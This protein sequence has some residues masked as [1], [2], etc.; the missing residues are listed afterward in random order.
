MTVLL[1]AIVTGVLIIFIARLL[2][3]YFTMKLFAATNLVAIAFIYIG[4]S[5]KDN[6]A[7]SIVIEIVA[8]LIFYFAALIG[9]KKNNSWIAWGLILH[10]IWDIAHYKGTLIGTVIPDY[11]PVYCLTIDII[12]GLFFLIIFRKQKQKAFLK[13]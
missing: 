9:Y 7:K 5:L 8:T 6:P 3:G 12:E 11:W 1:S 10:G 13:Q 2:S 4:F